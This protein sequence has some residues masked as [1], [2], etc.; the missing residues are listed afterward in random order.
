MKFENNSKIHIDFF[1]NERIEKGAVT[2]S[3]NDINF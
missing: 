2:D 3:L 1:Q